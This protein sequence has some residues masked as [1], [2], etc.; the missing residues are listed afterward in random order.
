[1]SLHNT[2]GDE[3]ESPMGRAG[4]LLLAIAIAC[5]WLGVWLLWRACVALVAP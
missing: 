5:S 2:C 3:H 1:M 4:L